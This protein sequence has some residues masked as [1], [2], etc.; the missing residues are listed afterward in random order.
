[1]DAKT[2]IRSRW[3]R[4]RTTGALL[5]IRCSHRDALAAV[6]RVDVARRGPAAGSRPDRVEITAL[7]KS[8]EIFKKTRYRTDSKPGGRDVAQRTP[9]VAG[10]TLPSKVDRCTVDGDGLTAGRSIAENLKTVT[11]NPHQDDVR[12]SGSPIAMTGHVVGSKRYPAAIASPARPQHAGSAAA[13][14]LNAKL[15]DK[16]TAAR[17]TIGKPRATNLSSGTLWKYAPQVG[18]AITGAAADIGGAL[19]KHSHA[20]H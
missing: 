5:A 16:V 12:F 17:N 3:P 20:Y 13:T 10:I 15:T 18:L 2:N 11:R 9:E 7:F 6:H 19:E 14:S 1:M 8:T 4:R